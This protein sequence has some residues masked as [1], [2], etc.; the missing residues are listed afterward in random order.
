MRRISGSA[1][2]EGRVDGSDELSVVFSCWA[3]IG[4]PEKDKD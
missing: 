2:F 3:W 1:L 4:R